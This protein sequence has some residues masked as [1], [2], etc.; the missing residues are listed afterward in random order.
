MVGTDEPKTQ[1]CFPIEF[2]KSS[3][4]TELKRSSQ[5]ITGD[6]AIHAGLSS[7]IEA[8]LLEW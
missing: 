8:D 5:R 3:N 1:F 2:D 7:G 4:E 6:L